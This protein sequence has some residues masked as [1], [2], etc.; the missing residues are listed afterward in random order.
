MKR[1]HSNKFPILFTLFALI[2]AASTHTL[3][4]DAVQP[5]RSVRSVFAESAPVIDGNISETCWRSADIQEGFF[6]SDEPDRGKPSRVSTRFWV[7]NDENY[8]YVAVEM[9][10]DDPQKLLKSITKRD[11][12]LDQDDSVCL[13]ID[14][15]HDYRSAYFFQ[16]N[17]I[18]TQ[19]DLYSTN[20]GAQVDIGWDG[21]W[22]AETGLIENGWVVEFRIPF[23]ILRFSASEDMVW[24]FDVVRLSKQREDFSE[25]CY[26]ETNQQSTL[27]P[28]L[29][30]TLTDLK[31]V[32]KP[33]MLQVIGSVVGSV[34]RINQSANPFSDS[35]GWDKEEDLDG[36]LD[37]FWG[38]TPKLTLNATINPDFAQIEADP[39]QLNL[40]GEELFLQE[41]RPFFREN[42]AIF[43][44]PDGENPFYS[45]RIV[46]IDQGLRI[47][48]QL[49]TSDVAALFVHG[50]DGSQE[51]NM[52]TVMRSQT[53]VTKDFLIGGWVIGKANTDTLHD[54]QN[55]HGETYSEVSKDYNLLLG[56]DASYRPGNW[57]MNLHA[58]RTWYP[59]EVRSW[60]TAYP[61]NERENLHFVLRYYGHEWMSSSDLTD[62]SMGYYPELGFVNISRMGNRLFSQYFSKQKT[63]DEDHVLN[64]MSANV[65]GLVAYPRNDSS[66]WSVLGVNG[67]FSVEFDN[68]ISIDLTGEWFDDRSFDKFISFPRDDD[69]EIINGTA[70]YYA[71]TLGGGN[72]DVRT[73]DTEIS[74]TDGGWKGAGVKYSFGNA[75]FSRIS[76]FN[77]WAN[78][79]FMEKL[80]T[81][82][83]C[84]YL[85]RYEP[86]EY[87]L[88]HHDFWE[89]WNI[90][91][92]RTK[93]MYHFT[94]DLYAR[95]IVSGY[96]DQD[97]FYNNYNISALLSYRFLPGSQLYIV[98]EN[99]W[100]PFDFENDILL[101]LNELEQKE[102]LFYIKLSYMLDV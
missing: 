94:R 56:L 76:Q 75:Y 13:Y 52:F 84:D 93:L 21:I 38:M 29:Y 64:S 95:T 87:Y 36:G 14:T 90:W 61:D 31:R 39:D 43:R 60:Y 42:S 7:M 101:G 37:L 54:Y 85:K 12:D 73:M 20:N 28:R 71:T 9:T 27:D 67:S 55:A 32:K 59:N 18:G 98:Y 10:G 34:K 82:L 70:R 92:F 26:V 83:S 79:N 5:V 91:I 66:H 63:F 4:T 58:Y 6:R 62:I 86:T 80:T 40:N 23:K 33:L 11:E 41:R 46:D 57:L 8:L 45:R 3:A 35:T 72:N 68:Q 81:E 96:L 22:E 47:T 78:W 74:W 100:M 30:G 50:E 88:D 16:V 24:G 99:S 51:E 1:Y 44:V 102:Q 69:G 89:D 19:R 48:G 53:P 97:R 65:T 17:P 49:G 77:V 25:W 2:Y 15:F